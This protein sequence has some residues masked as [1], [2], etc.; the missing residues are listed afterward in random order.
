MYQRKESL[1]PTPREG[2]RNTNKVASCNTSLERKTLNKDAKDTHAATVPKGEK[3]FRTVGFSVMM[4]PT[5]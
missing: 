1:L 4:S 5:C 3:V 2:Y